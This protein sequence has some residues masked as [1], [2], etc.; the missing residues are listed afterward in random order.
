MACV[1][2]VAYVLGNELT[3]RPESIGFQN[4]PVP[5]KDT[6]HGIK[7][8][9]LGSLGVTVLTDFFPTYRRI[10][11][12]NLLRSAENVLIFSR[13]KKRIVRSPTNS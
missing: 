8:I 9:A 7:P 2:G 5:L 3:E 12:Q 4:P 6:N 11:A 13:K 10:E 1:W